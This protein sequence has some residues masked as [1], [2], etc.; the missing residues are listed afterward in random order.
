MLSSGITNPAEREIGM[1]TGKLR[2]LSVWSLVVA[3]LAVCGCDDS[4]KIYHF[5]RITGAGGSSSDAGT[6]SIGWNDDVCGSS[7]EG[8]TGAVG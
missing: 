4:D 2:S 7:G 1:N 8:G 5:D 6:G 3:A